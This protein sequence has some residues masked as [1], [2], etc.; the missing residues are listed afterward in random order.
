[1]SPLERILEAYAILRLAFRF[2][3]TCDPQR[4]KV[5]P[6]M[7][8]DSLNIKTG[9]NGVSL[10]Q[11]EFSQEILEGRTHNLL[12]SA[13]AT[14]TITINDAADEI[15][16]KKQPGASDSINKARNILYMLP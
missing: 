9:G 12:Q 1:M 2:L 10:P 6:G 11:E 14:L 8:Q 5:T 4:P 13:L 15:W 16:G 3:K 7:L